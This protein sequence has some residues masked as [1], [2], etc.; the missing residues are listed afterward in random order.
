MR[1]FPA[2]S[3]W[4]DTGPGLALGVSNLPMNL[5]DEFIL[6]LTQCQQRLYGYIFRRMA[7]RDQAMEVLQQTNLVLCRKA[8]DFEPGTNFN[9]WAVTVAHYQVLAY[10]KTMAR[11]RLVFTD[12]V[13]HLVD[14]QEENAEERAE[15]MQVLRH[16]YSK[17]S[18]ENQ[19][20]MNLRYKDGLSIKQMAVE[21]G[22]QAGAVRVQLH[23]LRLSLKDCV[24]LKLKE[25]EV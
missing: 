24:R 7:N 15:Q 4:K 19:S 18:G 12:D 25:K 1:A 2:L 20:F 23:R 14:E 3:S 16:C 11:E 17:M 9:A 8:D 13:F 21:V 10:R 5:S 22:K 6:E